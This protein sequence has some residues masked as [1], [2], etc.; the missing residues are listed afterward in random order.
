V[1]KKK[2][3]DEQY[4]FNQNIP[5]LFGQIKYFRCMLWNNLYIFHNLW[6]WQGVGNFTAEIGNIYLCEGETFRYGEGGFI[7]GTGIKWEVKSKS[8]SGMGEKFSR[9][10]GA[11]GRGGR[12]LRKVSMNLLGMWEDFSR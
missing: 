10:G 7:P 1:H 5:V 2:E 6:L 11:G 12:N 8:Y 4:F 3:R 9:W